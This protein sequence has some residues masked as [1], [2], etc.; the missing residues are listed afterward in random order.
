[1]GTDCKSA[2]VQLTRGARGT[3]LTNGLADYIV[4]TPPPFN[5]SPHSI[6]LHC[7]TTMHPRTRVGEWSMRIIDRKSPPGS[8]L[9]SSTWDGG[10]IPTGRVAFL[11]VWQICTRRGPCFAATADKKTDAPTRKYSP[12]IHLP[13]KQ[14]QEEMSRYE[15]YWI[16]P[17]SSMIAF[18]QVSLPPQTL[19]RP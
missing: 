18:E 11:W 17:D 5:R 10:F 19:S 4:I 6:T 7:K 3:E 12:S 9:A 2:P 13:G 1:M 14:A 8:N 15:G 16:S